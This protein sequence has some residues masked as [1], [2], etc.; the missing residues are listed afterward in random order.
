MN[1]FQ[2]LT[3]SENKTVA[4]INKLQEKYWASFLNKSF[5]SISSTDAPNLNSFDWIILLNQ[6]DPLLFTG[7]YALNEQCKKLNKGFY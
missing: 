2:S 6:A 4:E 7:A 1:F 5:P 3:L